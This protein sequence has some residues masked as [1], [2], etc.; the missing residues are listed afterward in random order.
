[1]LKLFLWL[2]F[3]IIVIHND[4]PLTPGGLK[5]LVPDRSGLSHL[6]ICICSFF[7][8]IHKLPWWLSW[9]RV[10]LQCQRPRFDPWV[11]RTR[12]R[13]KWQSTPVFLPGE[14]HGQRSLVGCS[15]LGHK[16]SDTEWLTLS[17]FSPFSLSLPSLNQFYP[18]VNWVPLPTWPQWGQNV[19]QFNR[20][21]IVFSTNGAGTTEYPHA[22]ELIWASILSH[23]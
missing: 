4:K 8:L 16:E 9:W 13:R 20:K 5:N 14:F 1:M 19:R 11:G 23:L 21:R 3:V 7:K 15:P 22:K 6:L 18:V 12:W 2:A 17:L 10:C